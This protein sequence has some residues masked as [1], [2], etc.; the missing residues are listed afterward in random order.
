VREEVILGILAQESLNLELWLKRYKGFKFWGLFCN[1]SRARDL[2]AIIFSK[3]RGLSIKNMFCGLITQKSKGL[4]A[5][6]SN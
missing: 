4:L 1:F 3:T 5:R 6:F 2:F